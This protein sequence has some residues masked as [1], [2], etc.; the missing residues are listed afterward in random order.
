MVGPTPI[1]LIRQNSAAVYTYPQNTQNRIGSL[2]VN[3]KSKLGDH[4][5]VEESV[6][7]RSL[8]QHH[9]DGNNGDFESCSSKSAYGGDLCLQN[10][11]FG[12]PAGGKTTA[13]RNQ[14]VIMDPSGRVFP[15]TPPRFTARS[16]ALSPTAPARA[17][18]YS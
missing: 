18:R 16:T 4:W 5:Q 17:A 13:F 2:A 9:V 14:F 8:R 11:A 7:V 1:D 3:A 6:Y 10:D 15:S 12:T